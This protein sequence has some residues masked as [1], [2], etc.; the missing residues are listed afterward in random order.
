MPDQSIFRTSDKKA[1]RRGALSL[2]F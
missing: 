1:S 2:T